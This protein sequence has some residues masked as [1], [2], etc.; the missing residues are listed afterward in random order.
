[1]EEYQRQRQRI[2]T[3]EQTEVSQKQEIQ[4]VHSKSVEA[5]R[6]LKEAQEKEN[7]V[8]QSQKALDVKTEML[9]KKEQ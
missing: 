1:M 7:F 9:N 4:S 3:L 8:R 5:D 2:T 6:K